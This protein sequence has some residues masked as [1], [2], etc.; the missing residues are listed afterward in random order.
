[1]LAGKGAT[2]LGMVISVD[3][4][5]LSF[6]LSNP[7]I[8]FQ[9]NRGQREAL[10]S[11]C[12]EQGG[13]LILSLAA[14][15]VSFGLSPAEL[16]I[17][18][19]S[20]NEIG[21]FV[22]LDGNRRLAAIR[23][24]ESPG[25][26]AEVVRPAVLAEVRRLSAEY[27]RSPIFKIEC[28]TVQ[29]RHEADHWLFLRHTGRNSGA[30][31]VDW[32]SHEKARFRAMT[33][34][35]IELH[36][37]LLDFL[38]EGGHL[39]LSDRRRFKA[40]NFRRIIETKAVLERLGIV[41]EKDGSFRFHNEEDAI[42]GLLY[43]I[44]DLASNNV[45]VADIYTKEQRKEYAEKIPESVIPP[46]PTP[47]ASGRSSKGAAAKVSGTPRSPRVPLSRMKQ[48]RYRLIPSDCFLRVT[49]P[50]IRSIEVELRRLDLSDFPN[51][52]AVLFRVFLELSAD[53]YI[54]TE[55]LP[56]GRDES[57][58]AKLQQ[59]TNDLIAKKRLGPKQATPVRRACA[60]D[61]FLSPSVTL[62]HQYVHSQN[63][64]PAGGD[65]RAHW[66]GLQPFFSAIWPR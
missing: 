39:N 50:R 12:E 53:A 56:Q 60:K 15:I 66:D 16:P 18:M 17:V 48:P 27:L 43:I 10:L 47:A 57:L 7:R 25:A 33:G 51:A 28:F 42:K 55:Q 64:F 9:E 44:N 6:D 46:A 30:G 22:M 13:V 23:A 19:P 11:L 41:S 52:V 26:I 3:A 8:P 59:V 5:L 40:S 1:M 62:M 20:Q 61:S 14:D 29:E 38:E 35:K 34:A 63:V 54:D 36:T 24:L 49:N 32:G 2:G 21:R 37:R 4:P 31:I 65:L 45:K 58:R